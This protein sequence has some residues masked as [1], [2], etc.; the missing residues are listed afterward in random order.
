MTD[1]INNPMSDNIKD[2]IMIDKVIKKINK[3]EKC[4]KKHKKIFNTMEN[5]FYHQFAPFDDIICKIF[6][7]I[8]K[9]ISNFVGIKSE[10]VGAITIMMYICAIYYAFN[11]RENVMWIFIFLALFVSSLDELYTYKINKINKKKNK[12]FDPDNLK[13]INHDKKIVDKVN[14]K[15]MKICIQLSITI[16]LFMLLKSSELNKS[17]EF[18]FI[19]IFMLIA[20]IILQFHTLQ[21]LKLNK[22]KC[23]NKNKNKLKI[24]QIFKYMCFALFLFLLCKLYLSTSSDAEILTN[25]SFGLTSGYTN[26]L[27]NIFVKNSQQI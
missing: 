23:K 26:S 22:N 12:I 3:K 20:V 8:F 27:R 15:M 10:I 11:L 6:I 24:L 18:M 17:P 13:Y 4:K 2:D 5:Y 19:C 25:L 21:I 14:D 16:M 1:N 9:P 7:N